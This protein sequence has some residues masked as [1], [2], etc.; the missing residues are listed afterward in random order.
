MDEKQKL[1]FD[2]LSTMEEKLHK[3]VQD[4]IKHEWRLS[5]SIWGAFLAS[6]AAILGGRL[7]FSQMPIEPVILAGIS[8][9]IVTALHAVFLVW[10]QK[11]LQRARESIWKLR[12]IMAEMLDTECESKEF[13]R[14][15]H[16]QISMYVQVSISFLLGLIF[17]V[18]VSLVP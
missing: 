2:A 3:E 1:R 8:I 15:V 13:T 4:K 7:K 5:Y 16:K 9:V 17:L 6:S 10:I 11:S 14:R 12:K 18:I